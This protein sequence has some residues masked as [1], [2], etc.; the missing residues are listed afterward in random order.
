MMKFYDPVSEIGRTLRRHRKAL[1]QVAMISAVLNVLMLSGSFFMLLVY[2]EV[3][4]SRN[5]PTLLD[6]ILIVSIVYVFQSAL[7]LIRARAMIQVG[8]IVD[9]KVTSRVFDVLTRYEL[10][11]GGLRDDLQPVRDLDQ[12]R[13]F[14]TGAGPTAI[15]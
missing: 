10:S 2:D 1:V 7:D 11:R 15:G 13:T 9:Q 5:V 4:P 12:I 6:L 3:L 14:L 8:A